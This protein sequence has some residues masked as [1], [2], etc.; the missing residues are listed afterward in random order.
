MRKHYGFT[1]VE[2][3]VAI[4]IL[5]ILLTIGL[6]SFRSTQMS[7]RDREREGDVRTIANYIEGIYGLNISSGSSDI[8]MAGSYPSTPLISNSSYYD[9]TFGD[10]PRH[11]AFAPGVSSRSLVASTNAASTFPVTVSNIS[12]APTKDTYV[13]LPIG[14]SGSSTCT[15]TASECRSFR[16]Y[17]RSELDNQVKF[18]ESKRK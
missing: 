1:I 3:A 17:Y 14:G 12:P 15:S 7:A 9:A 11:A 2:L 4:A 6:V 5:V 16:I 18:V 10:L 13:Y 8:K